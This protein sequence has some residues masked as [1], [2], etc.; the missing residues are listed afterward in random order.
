MWKDAFRMSVRRKCLRYHITREGDKR[1]ITKEKF[2]N[3]RQNI[4]IESV[5]IEKNL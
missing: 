2:L 4:D 1:Y 3:I 5:M